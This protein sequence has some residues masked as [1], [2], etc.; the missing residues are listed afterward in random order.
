MGDAIRWGIV[1]TGNIAHQFARALRVL[2]EAQLVAVASRARESADRF[3]DEFGVPHRHVGAEAI[4]S[5]PDVDV[6]YVATPNVL[7]AAETLACLDGG[8]A[9]LCEKP[10][11]LNA[12]DA[13][14]MV[15]RA[16]EK[17]LFLMEAMWTQC[18]PAMRTIRGLLA[19]NAVGEIRLVQS[20]F[21]SRL[22][23]QPEGRVL[24]PGLG[25]GSLLD[26]GVY[27]LALAH[28]VYGGP[29]SRISSMAYIGITGVDE[30]G[31]VILGYANGAMAVTTCAV[32]TST[33]HDAYIYGEDGYI[34]IPHMYWQPDRFVL[35]KSGSE[36]ESC[37]DRLGNGY[38]YEALEVMLCL[39]DGVRES[40]VVP[41]SMSVDIMETMDEVRRQWGLVYE[42]EE[43][44]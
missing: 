19:S 28:M 37:F 15:A 34:K 42:T 20:N 5:D 39:R 18:F 17:N 24:N 8:K 43:R 36:K 6:V 31:A 30:Q 27:N 23:E 10:F 33:L 7:H 26:V 29:P 9:V 32:R 13:R 12:A 25:G 40:K 41:L 11:A 38:T 1:G 4:A 16:R 22:D 3:G 44:R 35:V 2:P 14:R 21:C